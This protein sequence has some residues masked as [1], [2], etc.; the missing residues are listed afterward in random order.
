DYPGAVLITLAATGLVLLATLGGTTFPW[1]SWPTAGLAVASLALLAA[2]VG[3][4]R[5]AA[6][7]V[8]PPG[9][10]RSRAFSIAAAIGFVAVF[11]LVGA[12]A[13]VSLFL[14]VV[15]HLPPTE[16]GLRLVPMMA[17]ALVGS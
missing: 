6:E 10:F 12:I 7:P 13:Y 1:R 8:I 16:A 11:A 9:L 17:G 15:D 3:V 4:E 5:R 2:F 14:Q